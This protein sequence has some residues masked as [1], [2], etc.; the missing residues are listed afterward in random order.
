MAVVINA[1]SIV[2]LYALIDWSSLMIQRCLIFFPSVDMFYIRA[3]GLLVFC[4]AVSS[5]S[6]GAKC[7]SHE[8]DLEGIVFPRYKREPLLGKERCFTWQGYFRLMGW[9]D[10]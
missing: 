5:A 8:S 2:K 6:I 4:W 3:A 7:S 10:F 9:Q 1:T